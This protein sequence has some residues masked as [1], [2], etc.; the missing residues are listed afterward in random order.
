MAVHEVHEELAHHATM[1]A[2]PFRALKGKLAVVTGGSR[3][4]GH[5]PYGSHV[6]RRRVRTW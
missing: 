3:G 6:G 5:S 2:A 1:E 4:I